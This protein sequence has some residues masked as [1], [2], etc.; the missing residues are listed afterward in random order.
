MRVFREGG[1]SK[2]RL[3]QELITLSSVAADSILAHADG[4]TVGVPEKL[5]GK[6]LAKV[7]ADGL[8][9]VHAGGHAGLFSA[10][11]PGWTGGLSNSHVVTREVGD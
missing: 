8:V 10:I 11:L 7:R 3:R 5:R 4:I 2:A 6:T 9:I 1:W